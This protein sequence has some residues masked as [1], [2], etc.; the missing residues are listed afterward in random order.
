MNRI[1]ERILT[2]T[3]VTALLLGVAGCSSDFSSALDKDEQEY[4]LQF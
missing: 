2:L 3:L 1:I 4:V